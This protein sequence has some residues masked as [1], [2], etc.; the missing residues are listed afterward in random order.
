MAAHTPHTHAKHHRHQLVSSR[1]A[2]GRRQPRTSRPWTRQAAPD[3]APRRSPCSRT[4][5]SWR[6]APRRPPHLCRRPRQRTAGSRTPSP[7]QA[8]PPRT[9]PWS[10]C[11]QTPAGRHRPWSGRYTA[12]TGL[13]Q[14]GVGAQLQTR[15]ADALLTIYFPGRYY[16]HAGSGL[17]GCTRAASKLQT[18]IANAHLEQQAAL[19]LQHAHVRAHQASLSNRKA[20]TQVGCEVI[21]AICTPQ[22]IASADSGR[23]TTARN[24]EELRAAQIQYSASGMQVHRHLHGTFLQERSHKDMINKRRIPLPPPCQGKG[25]PLFCLDLDARHSAKKAVG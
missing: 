18:P 12:G 16:S 11:R 17:A 23:L 21:P 4:R 10:S 5:R 22:H 19:L 15:T 14:A 25:A 20:S 13:G 24:Q 3:P 8:R 6:S 9:G 7:R 1:H 2:P